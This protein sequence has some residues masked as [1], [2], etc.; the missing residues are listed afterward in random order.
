MSHSVWSWHLCPLWDEVRVEA[1]WAGHPRPGLH[2]PPGGLP[3]W[4]LPP[5]LDAH[6]PCPA[7]Q[8]PSGSPPWPHHTP[9]TVVPPE[10]WGP[11]RLWCCPVLFVQQPGVM[12]ACQHVT[13]PAGSECTCRAQ[14]LGD[15]GQSPASGGRPRPRGTRHPPRERGHEVGD[16]IRELGCVFVCE[17]ETQRLRDRKSRW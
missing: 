5:Q 6:L 11:Q 12:W 8:A 1:E 16:F 3:C 7:M 9:L 13:P 14:S 15:A 17:T 2:L 4:S 10:A